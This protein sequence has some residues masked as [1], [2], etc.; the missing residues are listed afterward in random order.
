MNPLQGLYYVLVCHRC[1]I[2]THYTYVIDWSIVVVGVDKPDSLHDLHAAT[3]A[4][5]YR[6]FVV[7]PLGRAQCDEELAAIGVGSTVGQG[8]NPRTYGAKYKLISNTE[9]KR[10]MFYIMQ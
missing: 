7:E 10:D 5:E 4:T 2:G 3:D 6:V 9:Y 8:Q 1:D